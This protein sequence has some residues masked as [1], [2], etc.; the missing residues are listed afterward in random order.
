MIATWITTQMASTRGTRLENGTAQRSTNH[1]KRPSGIKNG[2]KRDQEW[3]Q[4][5]N[6]QWPWLIDQY[7]EIQSSNLPMYPCW[8]AYKT[9]EL[10]VNEIIK[11]IFQNA[12][13]TALFS[14]CNFTVLLLT[15]HSKA[16]KRQE[17]QKGGPQVAKKCKTKR[18]TQQRN[19]W[20]PDTKNVCPLILEVNTKRNSI[21]G[22]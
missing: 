5:Q 17:V 2:R 6:I 3:E 20:F 22:S 8:L 12:Y 21:P 14:S 1:T 7:V 19:I 10:S 18:D 16:E 15:N 13:Q 11:A 9:T 4:H